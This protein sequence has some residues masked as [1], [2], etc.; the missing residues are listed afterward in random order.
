VT[1]DEG[2]SDMAEITHASTMYVPVSDQGAALA[3]YVDVLG[4]ET[5][6]DFEYAQVERWIEVVPPGAQTS[7]AFMKATDETPPGIE[8]RS[9]GPSMTS[10]PRT[11]SARIRA[12]W[13]TRSSGRA[14]G[15]SAG[16]AP[17]SQARRP[18]SSCATRTGTRS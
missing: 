11:P 12:T 1:D 13:T 4:F 6:V 5:R 8:M 14:I 16:A 7:I 2:G 3:F 9:R 18:C 10:T 15:S 17:C